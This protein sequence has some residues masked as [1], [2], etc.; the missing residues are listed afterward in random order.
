MRKITKIFCRCLLLGGFYFGVA[1][2]ADVQNSQVLNGSDI[3]TKA[4][5]SIVGNAQDWGLSDEE[6]SHYQH[7]MAGPAGKW[8]AN[9]SPS[10]VL[11]MYADN[12]Q[13]QKRFAEM[14]A[15]EEHDRIAREVTFDNQ[16]H[17]A[18]HRLYAG[19]PVIKDFDM[20]AFNPINGKTR[21]SQ[22][23]SSMSVQAGDHLVLFVDPKSGLDFIS[24]PPL[25]ALVNTHPGV[26]LDI[27]CVGNISDQDIQ[28]WAKLNSIPVNL[29]SK[30]VI[31]LN[32]DNGKWKSIFGSGNLP[33]VVL[34][35]DGTTLPVSLSKLM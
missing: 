27:F 4:N 7:L 23:G 11:G 33:S 15:K 12:E 34:V 35:R 3:A 18:I 17:D 19:E 1:E 16:F 22:H 28:A 29:V 14:A 32:P 9:L 8:Y 26:V 30:G 25:L 2:A 21:P 31:T 13:D 20:S 5:G 6:W 24:V 10:E